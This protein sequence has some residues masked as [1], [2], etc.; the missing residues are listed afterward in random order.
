MHSGS[1][2]VAVKVLLVAWVAALPSLGGAQEQAIL[3]SG[4]IV[5]PV[6]AGNGMVASQEALATRIGVG[7]LQRGGNAVDAAVAVGFALAVT[8]PRAGNLGGG[9]FMMVHSAQ[10]NETV[11]IDYREMAPSAASRDMYLD[12]NGDVDQDKARFSY[13]SV[14]VPGS[15]A[16]L[17]GA[18]QLFG[19]MS[20]SAVMAPAIEL[21]EKGIV[22][23]ADLANSLKKR[24]QRLKRSLAS[25]Q[26]FYRPDGS[27]Y[28]RGD[29][30]VQTDLAQSMKLIARDGASAFYQGPIADKLVADMKLHD[31]L[32]TANDLKNYKIAVRKPVWGNYRGY[33]IASMPP[34]SSGGVHLVQILNILEGYPIGWLGQNGAE[35]VHL[36]AE[37]MKL[38][39]ADRAEYLGDPDFHKVPVA[40]LTSPGYAAQ[41]RAGINRYRA[42]PSSEI[43]YGDP[44]PWESNETTHF[45]IMDRWGNVVS[46]TYTINFS[47]GTG[48]VAEGTGIL[49]NNEMDDFSSK[50][51]VP[52][53]YGLVGGAANAIEPRKR[54]LSSMTPTI[55]F[56]GDQ[57]YLATGSPGGSRIITTTLQVIMNVIDHDM[58]VAAATMASRVHHQWLPDQLRVEKGL[59]PDTV[60]RLEQMGHRVVVKSAMGSTQSVMRVE[61]GFLGASDPRRPGALTLGY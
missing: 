51:G 54:P 37:A 23:T 45:S 14:G 17:A 41:L 18:L 20:L 6:Y 56:K 43:R 8:L 57:P 35:T 29:T 39:Y 21:A 5:H 16:G 60:A 19:S 36:M 13:Q 15:V 3:S 25:A 59:S 11:A 49:L 40:G 52:N 47:Y 9:G 26:I 1:R 24:E 2:W 27:L 10:K 61:Q 4:D 34:P 48:I 28:Q 22:V 55:V 46:N 53:A 30:L 7:I 50:P 31:G 33:R 12:Q 38:A 42:R 58:N 32:I 44:A